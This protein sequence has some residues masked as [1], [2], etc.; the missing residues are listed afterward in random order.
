MNNKQTIK[1]FATILLFLT[2][3]I[4]IALPLTA[5]A[6]QIRILITPF[7]IQADGN[8][9]FLKKGISQ[10][11]QS[12]LDVPG[13]SVPVLSE[14]KKDAKADD[15]L[16]GNIV[17][18]NNSVTTNAQLIN[19]KTG[20]TILNFKK[21]GKEKSDIL[22][23]INLL[24]RQI[25]TN[26]LH[27][28][29]ADEF[30]YENFDQEKQ[31]KNTSVPKQSSWSSRPFNKHFISMS[32][33]DINGDSKNE[34]IIATEKKVY[35]YLRTNGI[36]KEISQF[37]S[38]KHV[39]ILSVDAG[40]INKNK[41]AEIY[42]TCIN[43]DT[44]R[45]DS[46]IMEWNGSEF[47][48]IKGGKN[49][50]FRIIKT[51][52]KGTMLLGQIPGQGASMLDT[53]VSHLSWKGMKLKA[54]PLKLPKYVSLYS[55]TFGDVM[56]N[57]SDMLVVLTPT[58]KIEI[59]NSA[60]KKLWRSTKDF[61]GS[62]TCIE[63][64]GDFYNGDSNFQMSSIFLQQ[65][66]FVSDFDHKG[67]NAVFIVRN[68]DIASSLLANTRFFIK[69]YIASMVWDKT[70]LYPDSRTQVFTG[71]ISDYAIAD[72]NNDGKKELVFTIPILKEVLHQV[73]AS[74]IY[75]LSTM[76]VKSESNVKRRAR[77]AYKTDDDFE[78]QRMNPL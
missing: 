40:D 1:L 7:K 18:S 16:S 73:Y 44:T 4:G 43:E 61:G 17:I 72:Q 28:K 12:R 78:V 68:H 13:I 52:T 69:A 20:K 67:K 35:I 8:Y 57:G 2:L 36:F 22:T 46:F 39:K 31:T 58:G 71:Y 9:D 11:L 55:F 37:S 49:W 19:K 62:S 32:I 47:K 38:K 77:K 5:Q 60:G 33:A 10:M 70:G 14:S 15:T 45:P 65:R 26:V 66:I 41:K 75:S 42:V 30:G 74:R 25:K 54:K 6:K 29:P 64:K 48:E 24:A 34:T 27:V 53:P 3:F 23:H 21:T 63:Y 56:N 76:S 59:F 51:K 50:L